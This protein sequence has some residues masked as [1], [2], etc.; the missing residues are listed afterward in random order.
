LRAIRKA[1]RERRRAEKEAKKR[2]VD[3]LG[4]N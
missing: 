2:A 3:S 4:I 1:E